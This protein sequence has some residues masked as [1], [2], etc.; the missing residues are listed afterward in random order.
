M[1]T[2]ADLRSRRLELARASLREA[3]LEGDFEP[4]HSIVESL[5]EEFDVMDVAAAAIKMLESQNETDEADIP[6]AMPRTE[7]PPRDD[8]RPAFRPRER[9][10]ERG[11][12]AI[13]VAP[14]SRI[15]R[16]AGVEVGSEGRRESAC[17]LPSGPS[18]VSG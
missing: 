4:F 6:A 8:G 12:R 17:R 9:S 1:P 13:R 15:V 11:S 18:R 7:R 10:G 16:Q 3:I 2:V 14:R 5:A